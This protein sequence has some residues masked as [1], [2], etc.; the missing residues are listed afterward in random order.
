M[1]FYDVTLPLREGMTVFPG[2]PPFTMSPI[3]RITQG[4][5][6]NVSVITM[7]THTGTHV[8][9]PSHYFDGAPSVD[10][11]SPEVLIGPGTVLDLKGKSKIDRE[12]LESF[13]LRDYTR[14]FFKTDNGPKLLESEFY[15]DY[16]SLT[17]DGAIYLIGL[18]VRMVG[19]DYLSIERFDSPGAPV[20]RALLEAGVVVVEGLN[21]MEVPAG[22]C[23]VYCLPLKILGGDGAPARVI[24]ETQ[25]GED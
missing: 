23:R 14:V 4:D 8:D 18:G 5:E 15:R 16:V 6:I 25:P 17:E 19:I 11:I 1:P 7:N 2:D 9:P 24:V 22:P 21:L 10:L 13:G 12:A 20:H 3:F